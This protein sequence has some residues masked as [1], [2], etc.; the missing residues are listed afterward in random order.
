[1]ILRRTQPGRKRPFRTPLVWLVCPL[2]VVGC[3]L[4]FVNLSIVAKVVFLV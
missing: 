3:V 4:L 2:A 1:M